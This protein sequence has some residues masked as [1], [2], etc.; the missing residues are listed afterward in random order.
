MEKRT[1]SECRIAGLMASA[2]CILASMLAGG[3]GSGVDTTDLAQSGRMPDPAEIVQQVSES[4]TVAIDLTAAMREIA[5]LETPADVDAEVFAELKAELARLLEEADADGTRSA[6]FAYS[7]RIPLYGDDL[8]L[9]VN[10]QARTLR[11]LYLFGG[12]YDQNGSVNAAD[13]VPLSKHIGESAD[14]NVALDYG[15]FP[16][17]S[18]QYVVDGNF[19]GEINLSDIVAIARNFG[20]DFEGCTVTGGMTRYPGSSDAGLASRAVPLE[21]ASTGPGGQKQF[22]LELVG[23]LASRYWVYVDDGPDTKDRVACFSRSGGLYESAFGLLL[24]V[25]V[26]STALQYSE[27]A[28]ML[29]WHQYFA[30]DGNRDGIVDATDLTMIGRYLGDSSKSDPTGEVQYADY[31]QDS[32]VSIADLSPL[33][34][35]FGGGFEGYR[36]YFA[37]SE[38]Q[39]PDGYWGE[40]S[41]TPLLSMG[42]LDLPLPLTFSYEL[43]FTPASGSYLYLRP[44]LGEELGPVCEFVQVP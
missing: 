1:S 7:K 8:H 40:E 18:M 9:R 28:N 17:G 41:N 13:L 38:A 10:H 27:T 25:R 44:Y 4:G 39:L 2:A 14:R 16:A 37:A 22:E 42:Y 29:S 24:P 5:A 15:W 36:L 30:G 33:G 20:R 19:D 23:E 43:P 21:M 6:S 11:W 35:H 32:Q 31:N 26:E 12:D 34:L 3:C